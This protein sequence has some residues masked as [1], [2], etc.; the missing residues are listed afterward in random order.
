MILE[1]RDHLKFKNI[2][3]YRKIFFVSVPKRDPETVVSFVVRYFQEYRK[4]LPFQCSKTDL[5]AK[6]HEIC[7]RFG[8]NRF[9]PIRFWI[10]KMIISV[11]PKL[12]PLGSSGWQ[13]T[14]QVPKPLGHVFS[15]KTPT[16]WDIRSIF[17][18]ICTS[19]KLLSLGSWGW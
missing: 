4:Q 11:L 8:T 12:L 15:G 10:P 19:E 13:F 16:F 2:Q 14:R 7:V 1:F 18:T 6:K 9:V 17:S 5:D 3:F